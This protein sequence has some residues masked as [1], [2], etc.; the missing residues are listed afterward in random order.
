VTAVIEGTTDYREPPLVE[1]SDGS[2]LLCTAT[3]HTD[4]VLDL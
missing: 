2:V 4:L 1:P 3:P